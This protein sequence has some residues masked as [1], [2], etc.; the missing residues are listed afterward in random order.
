MTDILICSYDDILFTQQEDNNKQNGI[1]KSP[2][3]VLINDVGRDKKLKS[4]EEDR[5]REYNK[6][7]SDKKVHTKY[8][9]L[10]CY[11]AICFHN[12]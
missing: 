12:I 1:P 11:Y 8:Q 2:G 9:I 3:L 6:F 7:L 5:N 4:L 10:V